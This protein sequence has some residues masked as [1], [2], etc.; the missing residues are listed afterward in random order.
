LRVIA[1]QLAK[2]DHAEQ[3]K[4]NFVTALPFAGFVARPTFKEKQQGR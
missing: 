2:I 3:R 1:R 4:V